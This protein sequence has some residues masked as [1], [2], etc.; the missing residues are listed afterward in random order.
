[1]S[2]KRLNSL[3]L[4]PEFQQKKRQL[5]NKKNNLNSRVLLHTC[6][7]PHAVVDLFCG[8]GGLTHGLQTEGL[9]VVAGLDFD[10]T[11]KHAF[12]ANNKANFLHRDIT[13]VTADDIRCLYPEGK[14]KILV[15]CAPCQPFSRVPGERED[16]DE[17]WRLLYSFA[18]LISEVRPE[19]VSM[20]NVTLL[21]SYEKGK[22]LNDFIDTLESLGYHVSTY[23]VNAA[24][25]GVPQR[26]Y[27]LVLFASLIG[28]VDLIN[29]THQKGSYVTVH[30]AIGKLPHITAGQIHELDKLHRS[31]SLTEINQRRIEATPMGGDWTHWPSE[32]LTGLTCRET[33]SGKRFTSAYG[34]MSWNDVAPTLTT[35]CTGLS[36]GRYGHPAQ[37]RA[38][39]I[40]EAA[41]LQ[42]F[43]LNYQFL[44]SE[45]EIQMSTSALTRHIG[46]AVPPALGSAV[47]KSIIQHLNFYSK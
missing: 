6:V 24:N 42:S 30:D 27:R 38:I 36:N 14:I 28:K 41:L 1:M 11:C 39:S 20:E 37:H 10:N 23:R 9:N 29:P 25:Y 35:H 43:P 16:K 40:R 45:T 32:L 47:A 4:F 21:A 19:I 2:S 26:R 12:E 3:P 22:V 18:N 5:I 31:R 13:E 17:K 46:N 34:R 7:P 8:V 44:P 33:T 15:G